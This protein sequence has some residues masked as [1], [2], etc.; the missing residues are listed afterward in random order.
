MKFI[1]LILYFLTVTLIA[2]SQQSSS[3]TLQTCTFKRL[4]ALLSEKENYPSDTTIIHICCGDTSIHALIIA[5]Y[6]NS[7]IKDIS[8]LTINRKMIKKV[9]ELPTEEAISRFGNKW[10]IILEI[11]R[12]AFKHLSK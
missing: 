5:E 10:V 2:F 11:T 12:K 8:K 1:L 7:T 6:K 3:D 4:N 9:I